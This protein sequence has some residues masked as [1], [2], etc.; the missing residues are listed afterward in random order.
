MKHTLLSLMLLAAFACRP[1]PGVSYYD[2]Q[3]MFRLMQAHSQT[4]PKRRLCPCAL[5]IGSARAVIWAMGK[6]D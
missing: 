1:D 4:I 5:M 2:D 3:E 6:V